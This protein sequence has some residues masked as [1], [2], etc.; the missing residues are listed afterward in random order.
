M[1]VELSAEFLQ[2]VETERA[3][4]ASLAARKW[5]WDHPDLNFFTPDGRQHWVKVHGD[6]WHAFAADVWAASVEI[7]AS[8]GGGKATPTRIARHLEAKDRLH[9]Y[10][11]NSARVMVPNARLTIAA[12]ESAAACEP[13]AKF[14]KFE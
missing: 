9:G 13:H 11:V 2:R 8:L 1:P 12:L 4:R 10:T 7:E 5:A 14:W 3:K 6:H